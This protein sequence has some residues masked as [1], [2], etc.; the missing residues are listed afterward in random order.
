MSDPLCPTCRSERT[1]PFQGND[2]RRCQACDH[3]FQFPAIVKAVYD[4]Q[5]IKDRYDKYPTTGAMSDLRVE[6]LHMHVK[7]GSRILDVGA[8]NYAF[9]KA[10]CK[11][12]FDAWGCDVHGVDYGAPSVSSL[13]GNWDALC[14]FDSLEHFP[15]LRVIRAKAHD[16]S[17]I[18][19][20]IPKRPAWFPAS[21]NWR[22]YR[23]GEH[24][25]YPVKSSLEALFKKHCTAQ[26]HMED[27]IR[28]KLPSGEDN[29]ET[30]V[31]N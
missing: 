21:L 14:F 22:H 9:V 25:H 5:Y 27:T 30:L 15:D 24:L 3:I 26:S 29:I 20:S 12:G 31:F 11:D 18:I 4:H 7:S 13:D 16:V 6:M 19:V 23:P 28:G 17:T 1:L 10:A 8:G 2:L